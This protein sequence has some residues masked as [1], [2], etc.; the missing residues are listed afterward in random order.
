MSITKRQFDLLHAMGITVW[1]R[2][3]LPAHKS[4]PAPISDESTTSTNEAINKQVFASNEDLT[5]SLPTTEI[6]NIDLQALLNQQLFRDV[7]Q[8]LGV[9]RADLSVQNNQIDL[10]LI[11]WQFSQDDQIEFNHN[12]LKTPALNTIAHSAQL[13]KALWQSIGSLSST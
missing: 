7:I 6:I 1:Q 10:G 12:C 11:N 8:C 5:Q 2:R 9:S 4:Q 13:K 3:D